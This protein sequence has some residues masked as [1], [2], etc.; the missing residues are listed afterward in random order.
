MTAGEKVVKVGRKV[1]S[2][3]ISRTA[4]G[5]L[6]LSG[7]KVGAALTYII[8]LDIKDYKW[9][10]VHIT[11][12]TRWRVP[13]KWRPNCSNSLATICN[14]EMKMKVKNRE[15][16]FHNDFIQWQM[17]KFIKIIFDIFVPALTISKILVFQ[18]FYLEKVSQGDG[19][20]LSKWCHP[21]INTKIG[22][23]CISHF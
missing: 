8:T 1:T 15:Y 19:V 17:S 18:I 12:A 23:S 21:I 11:R 13:Y 4:C 6:W 7:Y 10:S 16:D 9:V 20:L 5:S 22:K 14:T 2:F 3:L